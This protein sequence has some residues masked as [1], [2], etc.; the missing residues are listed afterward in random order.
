M[1]NYYAV[2]RFFIQVLDVDD[3][4]CEFL[5]LNRIAVRIDQHVRPISSTKARALVAYLVLSEGHEASREAVCGLLWPDADEAKARASLRQTLKRLKRDLG[6]AAALIATPGDRLAIAP[7]PAA[8]DHTRLIERIAGGHDP[9]GLPLEVQKVHSFLPGLDG[10]GAAL[11][12]WLA[13]QKR[14]F[15]EAVSAELS[16]ALELSAPADPLRLGAARALSVLEPG[17]ERAARAEMRA[18]YRQGNA[19]GAADAYDRLVGVLDADYDTEPESETISLIAQIKLG[20]L[21]GETAPARGA[22]QSPAGAEPERPVL[23]IERVPDAEAGA[24]RTR[25]AMFHRDLVDTMVRFREWQIVDQPVAAPG[26]NVF[27]LVLGAGGTGTGGTG[28]G[29]GGTGNGSAGGPPVLRAVLKRASTGQLLWSERLALAAGDWEPGHVRLVRKFAVAINTS[30]SV[31]QLRRMP[32]RAPSDSAVFERWLHCQELLSHWSPSQETEALALLEGIVA[33]DPGFAPAHAEIA[34]ICNSRHLVYPGTARSDT[35]DATAMHH[36]TRAVAL[37][38]LDTRSQRVTAWAHLMQRRHG[39]AQ[40]HFEQALDLNAGSPYTLVS[41]A[42]G[43]A[44]CG[45]SERALALARAAAEI[46]ETPRGF[47]EGYLVGIHFLGGRLEEAV[48]VAELSSHTISN[49][50]GWKAAALWELGRA[51]EARAAADAFVDTIARL[52]CGEGRPDRAAIRTWFAASF[53]IREAA[54]HRRLNTALA[55]AMA[56]GV[57]CTG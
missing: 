40:I 1:G 31:A 50:L 55:A 11:D 2:F 26:A 23:A 3:R 12:S 15:A 52:W 48:A 29:T 28:T 39:L 19:S 44:F 57:T 54:V 45:N 41:C 21:P 22:P 27:R 46:D 10:L 35:L 9:T 33:E 47:L 38:P 17:N 6:D 56:P 53:P 36:A 30:L 49:L 51:D 5:L 43:L 13:V 42:Q 34:S 37:D 4:P 32:R 25:F 8:T 16:R 18:L 24:H 7:G 14:I 20:T